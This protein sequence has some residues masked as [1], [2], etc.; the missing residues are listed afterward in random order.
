MAGNEI[1]YL[2][3]REI[4]DKI[5]NREVS[6]VEVMEAHLTQIESV[7]PT[8]NAIVTLHSAQALDGANAADASI[9]NGA[10]LGP[11]QGRPPAVKD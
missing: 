1:C 11:L 8:V 3:A 5:R 6:A 9:S 4:R 10:V 2:D 7:N